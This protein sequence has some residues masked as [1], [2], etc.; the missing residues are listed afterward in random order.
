MMAVA[1]VLI[2]MASA[3]AEEN[4]VDW[5]ETDASCKPWT[6]NWWLGSAVDRENITRELTRYRDAGLGGIH[7]I[8]IYGA[9]GAEDR[10]ID[11]LSPEWMEMLAF[12]VREA[13]RLG[14]GVDMTT[15]T[16]WCFG[17]PNVTPELAGQSI[18]PTP[19]G[20]KIRP[21][22]LKVKRAAPG[23]AGFMIN[24]LFDEAGP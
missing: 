19:S 20:V 9:K 1:G 11:Y 18:R 23:G 16:G 21:S 10:S 14:L 24:P 13:K 5:P 17:G 8:P 3:H 22:N 6:Y 4:A 7:V 2:L 15:G 12:T